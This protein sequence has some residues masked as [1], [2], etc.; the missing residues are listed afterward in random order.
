MQRLVQAR[1]DEREQQ[2]LDDWPRKQPGFPSEA[3]CVRQLLKR[4]LESEKAARK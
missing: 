2:A 4:G 1:L 3:E